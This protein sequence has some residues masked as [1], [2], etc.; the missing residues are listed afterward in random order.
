MI[1]AATDHPDRRRVAIVT[2][3]ANGLGLAIARRLAESGHRV[4]VV[5]IQAELAAGAAAELD[6]SGSDVI[7]IPAD[8]TDT[9]AVDAMV[10]TT[11]EQFGGLDILVNNA[12]LAAPGPTHTVDDEAWNRMLDVHLGGSLRCARAAFHALENSAE[13]AV[14]NIAS[15]ATSVG[16]PMRASYAAAKSAVEGL[17]RVLAVE[18]APVGIRVNAVAPGFL[19]TPLMEKLI[20]EGTNSVE[21]MTALV[22]LNRLGTPEE[23]AAVVGFLASP[24]ASYLTG[25]SIIVDGGM[26]I[27]GRLPGLDG[28][29]DADVANRR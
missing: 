2:G 6:R 9:A 1:S 24:A 25:Q 15:I 18:W 8:V 27:D 16:M 20:A 21:S 13:P 4:A 28:S 12:G 7:A 19:L 3:G 22:P 5:D 23:I 10:N 11:V 29:V 26:T 17:T 14:V